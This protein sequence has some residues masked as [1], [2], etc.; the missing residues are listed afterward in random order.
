M[1]VDFFFKWVKIA[2]DVSR[3]L[4]AR[5][6]VLPHCPLLQ[7]Q[8]GIEQEA[9]T[10]VLHV[11]GDAMRARSATCSVCLNSLVNELVRVRNTGRRIS[12]Y[13]FTQEVMIKQG[14]LKVF[15]GWIHRYFPMKSSRSGRCAGAGFALSS[16]WRASLRPAD[17]L[18]AG[19]SVAGSGDLDAPLE[20]GRSGLSRNG[21]VFPAVFFSGLAALLGRSCPSG[22][23]AESTNLSK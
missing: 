1:A 18:G 3:T 13:W 22:L 21:L 14:M 8:D 23:E 11:F 17:R 4:D 16:V 6:P 20:G 2:Q 19:V 12:H 5:R 15:Q 10:T 7:N 9:V